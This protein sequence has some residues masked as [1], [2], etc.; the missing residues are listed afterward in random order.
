MLVLKTIGGKMIDKNRDAVL[1]FRD[2]KER[3]KKLQKEARKHRTTLS[4]FIKHIIDEYFR[5]GE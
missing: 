4:R 3:K 5:R 1:S 2:T